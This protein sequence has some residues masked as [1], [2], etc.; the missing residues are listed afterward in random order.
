MDGKSFFDKRSQSFV[1]ALS[2]RQFGEQ[3]L[4][5]NMNAKIFSESGTIE[6]IAL[7]RLIRKVEH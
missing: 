7:S 2:L 5:M 3:V 6:I 1:A 4:F